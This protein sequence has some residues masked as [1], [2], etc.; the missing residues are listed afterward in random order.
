MKHYIYFFKKYDVVNGM[1]TCNF[2]GA[3]WSWGGGYQALQ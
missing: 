3:I 2:I 1:Y